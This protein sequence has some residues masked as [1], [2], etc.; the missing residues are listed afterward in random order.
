VYTNMHSCN[1]KKSELDVRV[2]LLDSD[3]IGLTDMNPKNTKWSLEYQDLQ[4][5][6]YTLF[7]DLEGRGV[8]LFV[9][10]S[11][12]TFEVMLDTFVD[13]TRCEVRL[14]DHDS[15]LVGVV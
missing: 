5:Q 6:G 2:G 8:A 13:S 11:Y 9:R 1:N 4:L 12:R 3:I 10:K 15:L 14:S 7:V